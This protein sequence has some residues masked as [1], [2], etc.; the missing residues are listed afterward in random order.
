MPGNEDDFTPSARP[1]CH[2]TVIKLSFKLSAAFK[3]A[4]FAIRTKGMG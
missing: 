2:K 1:R 3:R 4:I